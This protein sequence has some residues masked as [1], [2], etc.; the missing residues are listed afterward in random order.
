[1]LMVSIL[2]FGRTED[3]IFV[4]H[5][6][7]RQK[8]LSPLLKIHLMHML[9]HNL[10]SEGTVHWSVWNVSIGSN[11]NAGKG[12]VMMDEWLEVHRK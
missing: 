9:M 12:G 7:S 8:A 3:F 6:S 1:M 11:M 10:Y 2:H 4:Q 5:D